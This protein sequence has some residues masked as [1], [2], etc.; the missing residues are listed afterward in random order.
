MNWTEDSHKDSKW[1]PWKASYTLL[2]AIP[3]NSQKLINFT[4]TSQI[5]RQTPQMCQVT[6]GNSSCDPSWPFWYLAYSLFEVTAYI[7]SRSFA[8]WN[9]SG[10]I[11]KVT[12]TRK[13]GVVIQER[14]QAQNRSE[15][16]SLRFLI[17]TLSPFTRTLNRSKNVFGCRVNRGYWGP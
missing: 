8:W 14:I 11:T 10:C 9:A 15:N 16:T 6:L 12:F 13:R 17:G 2:T 1:L 5:I 3:K 7:A 4:A